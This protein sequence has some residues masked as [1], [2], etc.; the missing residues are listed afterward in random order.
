VSVL[1]SWEGIVEPPNALADV[2]ASQAGIPEDLLGTE[3][4]LELGAENGAHEGAVLFGRPG[5]LSL[6]ISDVANNWQEDENAINNP[7]VLAYSICDGTTAC[8]GDV[9]IVG[10]T[11]TIRMK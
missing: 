11:P 1:A 10:A 2:N 9:V 3:F 8:P 7:E 6:A 5:Q 4:V